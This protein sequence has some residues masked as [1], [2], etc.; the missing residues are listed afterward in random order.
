MSTLTIRLRGLTTLVKIN[1]CHWRVVLPNALHPRVSRL[2]PCCIIEEHYA[3]IAFAE[4]DIDPYASAEANFKGRIHV[5]DMRHADMT[6]MSEMKAEKLYQKRPFYDVFLT[7]HHE[8]KLH[9]VDKG[10][11]LDIDLTE[12]DPSQP[13]GEHNCPTSLQWTADVGRIATKPPKVRCEVLRPEPPIDLVAAYLD[14][15][16]G[17]VRAGSI[18]PQDRYSFINTGQENT[19]TQCLAFEVIITM[20]IRE[21]A[22]IELRDR[23]CRCRE[24]HCHH[25]HLMI[26]FKEGKNVTVV[27]DNA[28]LEDILEIRR[29]VGTEPSFS[30]EPFYHFEIVYNLLEEEPGQKIFMPVAPEYLHAPH[31]CPPHSRC[32][33]LTTLTSEG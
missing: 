24:G 29:T 20:N 28:P 21:K 23:R 3:N 18:I 33:P 22:S 27:I 7:P 26:H 11:K 10:Q 6:P 15:F 2:D 4:S 9:G 14:I 16:H 13:P 17:E 30:G 12:I 8:I 1:H 5:M 32:S 19:P 25:D 31:L